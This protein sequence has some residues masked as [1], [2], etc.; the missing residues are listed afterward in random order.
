M[1]LFLC[2]LRL[3]SNCS[4]S[5]EVGP[6]TSHSVHFYLL[7]SSLMFNIHFKVYIF[8]E[9]RCDHS[10]FYMYLYALYLTSKLCML[11]CFLLHLG[12]TI[13]RETD[14]ITSVSEF[15][16]LRFLRLNQS[17]L[18]WIEYGRYLKYSRLILKKNL[19]S[20]VGRVLCREVK[21]IWTVL[22]FLQGNMWP[23]FFF[24]LATFPIF[25]YLMF[26]S[27][28]DSSLPVVLS[29]PFDICYRMPLP[30]HWMGKRRESL[31]DL[32]ALWPSWFCRRR[33]TLQSSQAETNRGPGQHP[34]LNSQSQEGDSVSH[35]S[36]IPHLA[37]SGKVVECDC[38]LPF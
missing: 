15:L 17:L 12:N 33:G 18:D 27:L 37:P 19:S 22:V 8:Q 20:L 31:I 7:K 3:P 13:S 35:I 30:G 36:L 26:F 5:S 14:C 9:T 25:Y 10:P 4:H 34:G 16:K 2:T 6:P 29:F 23:S 11:L 1:K 32:H 24:F 38:F 21:E 28:L